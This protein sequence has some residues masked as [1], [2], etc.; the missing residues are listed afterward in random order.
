[1]SR[2]QVIA[3]R[4]RGSIM[5]VSISVVVIM[6]SMLL[7]Y[8]QQMRIET[9][10]C[11]N[12]AS[13]IQ[14]NTIA[15]GVI[16]Y[17]GNQ[18][19]S[20]QDPVVLDSM[21]CEGVPLGEGYFWVIKPDLEDETKY[22]FGLQDECGKLNINTAT[23]DMLMR[24]PNMTTDLAAAI[25]D[26]RD[27][28]EN[29]SE[30]GGAENEYYLLLTDPYYCKNSPFETLEEIQYVKGATHELLYGSDSNHN[31]V[32]DPNEHVKQDATTVDLQ[33]FNGNAACGIMKY[34]TI[35]SQEANTTAQGR[36]RTNINT[37]SNQQLLQLFGSTMSTDRMQ[38]I[39]DLIRSSKPFRS[40]FDFYFK[41]QLTKAEFVP[42]ID[43]ITIDP[44]KILQ[45]RVNISTAPKEVLACLPGLDQNDAEALT[46]Q[47]LSSSTDLSNVAWV[48]DILPK[49][50]V[51]AISNYIGTK[52]KRFS[53]DIVAVSGDGRG[54]KRI[55]CVFDM[56]GTAPK[57][58]YTK[59]LTH[60]GW[61]LDPA[62]LEAL[63]NG[64]QVPAATQQA[65]SFT[66]AR[67]GGGSGL[68][69]NASAMNGGAR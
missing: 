42:I 60:L 54:Y 43:K 8:A 47:R 39:N 35:Y 5:V 65:P 12:R 56:S 23:F 7:V 14:A 58:L 11:A 38:K 28:D 31:G 17:I 18:L 2:T 25:I 41:L 61:P 40:I 66:N 36:P 49:N 24:L 69:A 67:M 30:N 20:S 55:R 52:T 53:A 57:I 10:A 68:L 63:R 16:A 62:I 37:A 9:Q 6:A 44:G 4:S 19:T 21:Q 29:V 34:L 46:T 48:I 26:W 51:L 15:H 1:M 45:G 22:A 32:L 64:T 27:A 50:K 3:S 13:A 59:D 33:G